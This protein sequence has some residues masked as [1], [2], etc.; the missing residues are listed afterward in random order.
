L[1]LLPE[2]FHPSEQD[3]ICGRGRK[4]FMHIG[5]ERFRKLVAGRL[6]DYSST[7]TKLEKS[8]ILYHIVAHVRSESP[9][10]GFV[11]KSP[12]NS[13]WYEIGDF[14]SREKTSQAFRDALHNKYKSSNESKKQ[15]RLASPK[16]RRAVSEG[17]LEASIETK[18]KQKSQKNCAK[19]QSAN[20]LS[21]ESLWSSRSVFEDPLFL[22]TSKKG[23]EVEQVVSYQSSAQESSPRNL[24]AA[25]EVR[26]AFDP[27]DH[28]SV[29]KESP[30]ASP[31]LLQ[32]FEAPT[33]VAK[34][35]LPQLEEASIF[36][37]LAFLVDEAGEGG[38]RIEPTSSMASGHYVEV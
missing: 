38:N 6:Q 25:L 3:V 34:F 17:T 2:S 30:E 26:D 24:N 28:F 13:R 31:L 8:Y 22:G 11:K 12:E 37:Q 18:R 21:E 27:L 20:D 5:N 9:N 23:A 16:P 1:R 14:L 4:I 36:D 32:K 29:P 15:R 10:A 33:P 35:N 19:A 7:S